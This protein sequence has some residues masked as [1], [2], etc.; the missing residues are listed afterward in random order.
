MLTC[1]D[2][3]LT[4]FL[5]GPYADGGIVTGGCK[6]AVVWTERDGADGLAMALPSGEVVHVWL[7]VL[8]DAGLV[9]RRQIGTRMAEL[10]SADC[11]V[12]GLEN[13]LKVESE[14][15][16]KSEFA[17]CGACQDTTTFW[18]PLLKTREIGTMHQNRE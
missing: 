6:S 14:T 9:C 2:T 8:D 7:K 17:A 4:R 5:K 15:I 3:L 13:G 11:G 1:Q 10:E 16:P 18:C 12:M